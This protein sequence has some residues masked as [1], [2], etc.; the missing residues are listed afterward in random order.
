MESFVKKW[1]TWKFY[2]QISKN[3]LAAYYRDSYPGDTVSQGRKKE[4]QLFR[5]KKEQLFLNFTLVQFF[6]KIWVNDK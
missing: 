3:L 5:G 1:W 4:R 6:Q 2:Q